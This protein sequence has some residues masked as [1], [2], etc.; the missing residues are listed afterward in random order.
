VFDTERLQRAVGQGHLV[1]TEVAD[2][3][4]TRG[5]SFRQA[6]DIAGSLVRA[7]IARG[8]TLAELP[9]EVFHAESALFERDV[10]DWLDVARAVDRRDVT[11]GP[12][13]GQI[14]AELA[15]IRQELA[16]P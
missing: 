13:R 2:Y 10:F 5:L 16:Q 11:G 15:R 12:A 3:L 7:A 4:V 1:A 14:E 8:V 6:H 9:L